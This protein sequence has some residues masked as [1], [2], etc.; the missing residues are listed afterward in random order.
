[1]SALATQVVG[2]AVRF[3]VR[4][5]PRASQT[6]IVG[7]HGTGLKVRVTAPPVDG[8]ANEAL[9][10]LIAKQLRIARSNVTV[11]SGATA[12]LKLVEVRGV[13]VLEV[14]ALAGGL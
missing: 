14:E 13:G 12:R 3:S 2:G 8:A 1:V 10:G 5:Q 6:A 11:I 4:V 7:V 9:V